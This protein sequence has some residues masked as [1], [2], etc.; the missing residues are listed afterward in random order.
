MT[1]TAEEVEQ[2]HALAHQA[3]AEARAGAAFAQ[4]A[5]EDPLRLPDFFPLLLAAYDDEPLTAEEQAQLAA[6]ENALVEAER[7]RGLL[8]LVDLAEVMRHGSTEPEMLVPDLL[9]RGL[10]HL[11]YGAKESAKTWLLL[12]AAAQLLVRGET[13]LWV[14]K[15]MGRGSLADRLKTLA[16]AGRETAMANVVEEHLVYC[17]HPTMDRSAESVA[18]WTA[19]L[20]N[21]QPALVIIDA[22]TEVLA[23]AGLNENIGTDVERWMQSYLTPARRLGVTT[24]FLDHT[25][26]DSSGRAVSS[27]QKG[28]AAKVELEVVKTAH[29]DRD[30]VGLVT[31]TRNKNTVSAP[32]PETQGFRI[33]G[34]PFVLEPSELLLPGAAAT[35]AGAYLRVRSDIRLLIQRAEEP[36]TK[37]Q[38]TDS[39]SGKDSIKRRAL[40]DLAGD[41]TEPVEA[42]PGS[43]VGSLLY[44]WTGEP[45]PEPLPEPVI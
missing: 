13:V 6:Y 10:H 2:Q 14:D 7:R 33:G 1:F 27:R 36:L 43:R 19:L 5:A 18:L 37:S 12:W 24:V 15:E 23:D 3:R 32:I 39:I 9:V 31:V 17:E 16:G 11:I 35:A 28:A 40:A 41:P 30:T 20:Q 29:F 42:R 22:Q 8:G 34:T 25:P 21:R 38:I 4:A 44:S 26:L 45:A